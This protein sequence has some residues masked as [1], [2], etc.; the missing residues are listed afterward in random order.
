MIIFRA[1]SEQDEQNY[2]EGK[3]LECVCKTTNK[4]YFNNFYGTDNAFTNIKNSLDSVLTHL[5]GYELEHHTSPW[6]SASRN[7]KYTINSCAMP[8]NMKSNTTDR[9]KVIAVIDMDVHEDQDE[10]REYLYD[11]YKRSKSGEQIDTPEFAIDL[12]ENKL[13]AYYNT[14]F[15]KM[16]EDYAPNYRIIDSKES[17]Q[18]I[19]PAD[20]YWERADKEYALP[21]EVEFTNESREVLVYSKIPHDKIVLMITPLVQDVIFASMKQGDNIIKDFSEIE[22]NIIRVYNSLPYDLK[23][24]FDY[25]YC[26]DGDV[27]SAIHYNGKNE[28]ANLTDLVTLRSAGNIVDDY[29][30]LRIV[31]RLIMDMIVTD[32]KCKSTYSR[33][34][35]DSMCVGI[36]DDDFDFLLGIKA[37]GLVYLQEDGKLIKAKSKYTNDVLRKMRVRY[38]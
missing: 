36:K 3:D 5:S 22:E 29:S 16:E 4:S 31:K 32:L 25:L 1:L 34:V 20:Y 28:A 6:I 13:H 18:D 10:V 9:R 38:K 26:P 19:G 11:L 17:N 2:N 14:P 27:N 8:R 23:N 33:L 21:K 7:L 37:D 30:N 12:G 24:L 15:R 35:D